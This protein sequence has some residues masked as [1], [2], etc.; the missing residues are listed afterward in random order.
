[1]TTPHSRRRF[2]QGLSCV[3]LSGVT[4]AQAPVYTLGSSQDDAELGYAVDT[5]GDIL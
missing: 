3:A 1:M 4:H 5:V 2:L